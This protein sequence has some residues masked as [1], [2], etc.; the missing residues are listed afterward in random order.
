MS[1]EVIKEIE[2]T[3]EAMPVTPNILEET[4]QVLKE[5]QA[6]NEEKKKLLE[7]EE[8][9]VSMSI[10]GGRSAAGKPEIVKTEDEKIREEAMDLLKGTGLNPFGR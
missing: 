1:E 2:K 10:L 7:R 4:R 6:A 3:V 5:L 9:I 8:K